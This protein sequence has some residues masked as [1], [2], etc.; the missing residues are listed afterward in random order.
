MLVKSKPVDPSTTE[1]QSA[2]HEEE[3]TNATQRPRLSPDCSWSWVVAVSCAMMNFFSVVMI[4]SAGLVYV[5][6]MNHF[7]VTR[8]EAAWPISIVPG[9]AN[10]VG[11]VVAILIRNVGIRP[12]VTTGTFLSGTSVILC[13]FAPN[14]LSL[15]IILGIF[16]GLGL[17][18]TFTPNAICLNEW[19]DK[20]KVRAAGIIYTGA[21]LGSFV[22]PVFIKYCNEAFGF[23]G[24]FLIVGAIMLHAT[25]FS[26]F[27]RSPPWMVRRKQPKPSADTGT[28][29]LSV[30]GGQ[31]E[32][33]A[34]D[35]SDEKCQKAQW[36]PS[37]KP[38]C[39]T[40]QVSAATT[41]RPQFARSIS[42]EAHD[43]PDVLKT[44]RLQRSNSVLSEE[45]VASG[46]K[47]RSHRISECSTDEVHHAEGHRKRSSS[48]SSSLSNFYCLYEPAAHTNIINVIPEGEEARNE[49]LHSGAEEK[50]PARPDRH[51]LLNPAYVMVC[52]TYIFVA[53]SNMAFMTV[54]MDFAHDRG[55]HL[56]KAVYLL[57]AYAT[58][59]IVGRLSIGWVTDSG[60]LERRTVMAISCLTLGAS[61]QVLPLCMTFEGILV[62]CLIL[63]YAV[64][65]TV[66]LFTVILADSVGLDRLAMGMGLMTF[67]A[68][69]SGFTRPVLIGY[70]RDEIGSYDNMLRSLGGAILCLGVCWT[71]LKLF[72]NSRR[73]K[74]DIEVEKKTSESIPGIYII[75]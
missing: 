21:T 31:Q 66:V 22:F 71:A 14:V 7:Q 29:V 62:M 60:L 23:Y 48:V 61:F 28:N 38:I 8:Q 19:F 12:V 45:S 9:V 27:L 70:F 25:A 49:S 13:Y 18:M 50:K 41:E 75:R 16:H 64:G 69:V 67:F 24:C 37:E 57:S 42:Q 46:C 51:S 55:I 3:A 15:S 5:Q 6:I 52:L 68:G 47:R 35:I 58:C 4:R 10:L 39:E 26:L 53:N 34:F 11:P 17:G 43:M 32:N 63:G 20:K 56:T 65:N 1:S 74:F 36:K 73:K 33:K 30:T 40:A 2:Q 59:D 54:L 72:E 44:S